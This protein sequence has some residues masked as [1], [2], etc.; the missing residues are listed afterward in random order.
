ML[1]YLLFEPEDREERLSPKEKELIRKYRG[2]DAGRKKCI[3]EA[4]NI[5][6]KI[7]VK[8]SKDKR[9]K[10]KTSKTRSYRGEQCT[11]I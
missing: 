7:V 2:L 10:M 11:T 9:L 6:Q 4:A 3:A 1:N 8:T 5:L